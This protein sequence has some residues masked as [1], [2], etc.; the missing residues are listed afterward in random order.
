MS[1]DFQRIEVIT[2]TARRRRWTTEHTLRLIEESFE[3]G[4]TVSSVARRNGVAPNLLYRWRRL[5]AEGGTVA[6]SSDDDVIAAPEARRLEER[7]RE[8]ERL[9]G[10]K[11]MEHEILRE[12]L[13]RARAKTDLAAS[14][15]ATGRF[16]MSRVAE[17]LQ[18]SR[19]LYE[20][21]RGQAK[22]RGSYAKADDAIL[23]SLIRRFVGERPT[24]G[25]RRINALVNR[26]LT[27]NC[28][29]PANRKRVHRIMQQ[30]ALLLERHTAERPRRVHD[31][32]I[33]MV[34]SNL[35]WCS[36]GLEFACWNGNII[37]LTFIIDAFDREIIAWTAVCGTG[38][39]GSDVRDMMLEVVE[40]R[41]SSMRAPHPIEHL[42]DNGSPYTAKDTCKFAAALNLVACFAPVQSPEPNGMSE[43]FVKTLKR[44]YVR[45]NPLLDAHTVR[46]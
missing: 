19:S 39:S 8:L 30:N 1:D 26:E 14:V 12:A 25:Y 32:K 33:M 38:I 27:E 5:M 46:R 6:V 24:Y 11:T 22:S 35:R 34:A 45:V 41:F 15:A 21:Q 18:V 20:R 23:L 16:P 4:D 7:M 43:A 37:C 13:A 17:M 9:L 29:P 40:K 36:D 28:L 31:G 2:G 10:R 44:D 3:P 42:S